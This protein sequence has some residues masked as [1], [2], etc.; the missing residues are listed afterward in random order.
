[1]KFYWLF[2]LLAVALA[3]CVCCYTV[4]STEAEYTSKGVCS[5]VELT[6]NNQKITGISYM[7]STEGRTDSVLLTPGQPVRIPDPNP[8]PRP[9]YYG[10]GFDGPVRNSAEVDLTWR[11]LP[12]KSPLRVQFIYYVSQFPKKGLRI[13]EN[14]AS[15]HGFDIE[16]VN[17]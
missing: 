1:M 6:T 3:G 2:P 12:D 7:Y 17:L 8:E 11:C 4:P 5:G 16:V 13:T 14:P 9:T 15:P 10:L